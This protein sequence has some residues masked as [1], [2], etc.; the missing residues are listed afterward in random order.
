MIK[1][2]ELLN[3]LIL[4]VRLNIKNNNRNNIEELALYFLF[5]NVDLLCGS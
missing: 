5:L 4:E 3:L 2:L 1:L